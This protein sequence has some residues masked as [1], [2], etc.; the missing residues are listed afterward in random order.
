MILTFLH[1]LRDQLT[2][3]RNIKRAF[4]VLLEMELG[5][6][7]APTKDPLPVNQRIA[8]VG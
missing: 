8:N 6:A 7:N 4:Q 1:W 2:L 5:M 3:M